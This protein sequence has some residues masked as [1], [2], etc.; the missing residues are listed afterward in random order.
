MNY[1]LKSRRFSYSGTLL[2]WKYTGVT[3]VFPAR[4]EINAESISTPWLQKFLSLV[5]FINLYSLL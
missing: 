2:S 5:Q 3:I 1:G 4:K